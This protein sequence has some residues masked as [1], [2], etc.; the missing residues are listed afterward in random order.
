MVT[1]GIIVSVPIDVDDNKY[2]VRLPFFEDATEDSDE[3]IYESTLAEAPGIIQGYRVGDVVYCAF[4]DNNLAR[5]VIIGK[6]FSTELENMGAEIQTLD[7]DVTE[8][9]SLPE[10]TTIG[11]ATEQDISNISEIKNKVSKMG[12]TIFGLMTFSN[13]VRYTAGKQINIV[14]SSGSIIQTELADH[15]FADSM[16][17][18]CASG[19][20]SG[21]TTAYIKLCDISFTKHY[22][23]R[24]I[25]F[26]IYV[27]QGQNGREDQNAYLEL[28]LQS[29]WTGSLNGRFGGYW[30]LHK[31][32]TTLTTNNFD[33]IVTSDS[34]TKYSVWLKVV[35]VDYCKPTYT[36]W[37][38]RE[39]LNDT[40]DICTI[41][42]V[43]NVIQTTVPTGTDDNCT[44]G[45]GNSASVEYAATAGYADEAGSATKDGSNNV[46]STTYLKLSGGKMTGALDMVGDINLTTSGTTSDDSADLIW[47]YGD[48]TEKMRVYAPNSPTVKQGPN[49]RIR[50]KSASSS[51]FMYEGTLP[52]GD[53]TGASGTW[54]IDISGN[55]ATATNATNA[56][57]ADA[58]TPQLNNPTS[59]ATRYIPFLTGTSAS[60]IPYVNDGL[61][62]VTLEGT[63][64]AN[65]YGVLKLGNTTNSGTA[66]NKYGLLDLYP[67][68]GAYYGRFTTVDTLTA[69][70]T[71][72]FPNTSGTVLLQA[73]NNYV[74]LYSGTLSSGST[75]FTG[76]NYSAY[77]IV[78][79]EGRG[80][81]STITV[82][83]ALITTTEE[84]W[85]VTFYGA[86]SIENVRFGLKASAATGGTI[87]LTWK[88]GKTI[89]QIYGIK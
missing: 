56:D 89:T 37:Y 1:K 74:S 69:N 63:A 71:Y 19:T 23:A 11:N 15:L 36:V 52:L 73:A 67:K 29:G 44:I 25:D 83:R 4:E 35:E 57:D 3:I 79:A 70:R 84:Q 66:G 39:L 61:K 43:G 75:T 10:H 55:A 54:G 31:M 40:T 20:G 76:S 9:A 59:A 86:S 64:S 14:D 46:I 78:G 24:F 81:R 12:D 60:R 48:G 22:Q 45:H 26:K 53:G 58:I 16:T 30:E 33:I 28:L 47:K 50:S 88:S 13:T 68:T 17:R 5:P 49:F 77:L 34:R 32:G 21:T 85:M 80:Y 6:L 82:P 51:T 65:G 27:G 42:H 7:L 72:T 87:T 2:E 41:T 38:D 8:R 62:Y 18:Q